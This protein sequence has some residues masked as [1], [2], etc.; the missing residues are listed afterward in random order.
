V[1]GRAISR[2]GEITTRHEPFSMFDDAA[3]VNLRD[4]ANILTDASF[5]LIA[6]LDHCLPPPG[7]YL[8]KNPTC[9][10]K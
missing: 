10:S 2:R 9:R 7:C 6:L 4:S 1:S 5:F 3:F 8:L